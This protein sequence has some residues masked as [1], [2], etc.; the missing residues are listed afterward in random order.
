MADTLTKKQRSYCM[1]QI[2]SKGTSHELIIKKFLRGSGFSYQPKIEGSPDFAHKK[3]KIAIFVDGCFWHGCPKCYREPKS[4]REYWIP[5]IKANI[6]RDNK[7]R[8]RLR[9]KGWRVIRIW[10]CEIKKSIPNKLKR[11]KDE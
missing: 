1:S 2:K 4:N 6:S 9:R 7:K 10:S 11:L 3:K 8:N 5:K